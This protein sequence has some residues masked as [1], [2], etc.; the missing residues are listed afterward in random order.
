MK[1]GALPSPIRRGPGA[2][3]R[4]GVPIDLTMMYATHAAFRRDLRLLAQAA[5]TGDTAALR[6]RWGNFNTQLVVH[7]SVED[8]YL[9]PMVRV[10]ASGRI[11]AA[12]VLDDM[13]RE[14][15]QLEP[16]LDAADQALITRPGVALD[17]VLGQLQAVLT[18]HLGHEE[19]DALPL[20]Q[21]VCT[22]ADWRRFA[23]H[24]RRRQGIRGAAAY[25]PWI[26][27]RLDQAE[28]GRFLTA[29]PLARPTCQPARM[30]TPIPA[31]DTVELMITQLA[32]QTGWP[33][34]VGGA[35]DE[36]APMARRGLKQNTNS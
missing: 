12:Q 14:H 15:S 23:G 13:E 20:I 31:T 29:L 16:L 26:L 32:R 4:S 24:M 1:P 25:V 9:W 11:G 17:E 22:R 3:R 33:R 27:D 28:R 19:R 21:A 8:A 18:N 6:A 10:A 5:S 34:P 36:A 35:L 30:G 7:H 2:S